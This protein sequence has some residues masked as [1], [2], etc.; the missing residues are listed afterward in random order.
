SSASPKTCG[1]SSATINTTISICTHTPTTSNSCSIASVIYAASKIRVDG[2][3]NPPSS[4]ASTGQFIT[5][6]W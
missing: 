4:S 5:H 1:L 3:S 2:G 6:Y